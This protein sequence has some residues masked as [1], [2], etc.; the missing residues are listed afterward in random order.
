MTVSEISE[1]NFSSISSDESE[2]EKIGALGCRSITK[3]RNAIGIAFFNAA[4]YTHSRSCSE[5]PL[6]MTRCSRI[7]VDIYGKDQY[8][9][10]VGVKVT[11]HGDGREEVSGDG[12]Q[13]NPE[14]NRADSP[15]S[16]DR[17]FDRDANGKW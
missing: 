13:T 2:E 14:I 3:S 11:I 1:F 10:T 9:N 12:N 6:A 4:K 16:R 15:D 17:D 7:D 8:G 5:I